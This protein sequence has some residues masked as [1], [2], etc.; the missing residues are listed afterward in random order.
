MKPPPSA[1][2]ASPASSTGAAHRCWPPVGHRGPYLPGAAYA[3]TARACSLIFVF[4]FA[5]Q[6]DLK[7]KKQTILH[8]FFPKLSLM[9]REHGVKFWFLSGKRRYSAA[10]AAAGR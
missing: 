6:L 5:H 2:T 7:K 9:I 1:Q 3:F 8:V 4:N 10:T